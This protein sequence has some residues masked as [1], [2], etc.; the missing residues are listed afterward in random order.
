MSLR[1]FSGNNKNSSSARSAA[2]SS[3]AC[4]MAKILFTTD[5]PVANGD[6]LKPVA[7]EDVLAFEAWL[8]AKMP[9]ARLT[10][11]EKLILMD[12]VYFKWT[13]GKTRG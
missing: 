11:A 2:S 7:A 4:R 12:Y 3:V 10:S 6:Q 8:Q 9:G 1:L 5:E 13:E